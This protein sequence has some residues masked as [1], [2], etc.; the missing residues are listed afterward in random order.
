MPPISI[1]NKYK[2]AFLH[3][4]YAAILSVLS[5][6]STSSSFVGVLVPLVDFDMLYGA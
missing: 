4:G 2:T 1:C 3:P 6:T 5:L